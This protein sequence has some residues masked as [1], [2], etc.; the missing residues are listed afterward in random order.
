MTIIMEHEPLPLVAALALT[1]LVV[2]RSRRM[3]TRRAGQQI[4][5]SEAS[6]RGWRSATSMKDIAR[7]QSTL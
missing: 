1:L 6:Q 5:V 7:M 3:Q 2:V 4:L